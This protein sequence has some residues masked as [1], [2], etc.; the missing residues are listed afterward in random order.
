MAL[1][2]THPGSDSRVILGL[3]VII[4]PIVFVLG[5]VWVSLITPGHIKH[6]KI[7][8]FDEFYYGYTSN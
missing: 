6:S 2:A 5:W 4:T 7:P 1:A 3:F 8:L